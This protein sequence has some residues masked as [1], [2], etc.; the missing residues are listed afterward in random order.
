MIQRTPSL[1][2]AAAARQPLFVFSASKH[3]RRI[4]LDI[5]SSKKSP[6]TFIDGRKQLSIS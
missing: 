2:N 4:D 1:C 5:D 3:R 6:R